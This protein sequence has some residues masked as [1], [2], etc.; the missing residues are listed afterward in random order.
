ME[1]EQSDTYKVLIQRRDGD[2]WLTVHASEI[3]DAATSDEA[4]ERFVN[5]FRDRPDKGR[6]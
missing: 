5:A 6:E 2:G 4:V 1:S 3:R